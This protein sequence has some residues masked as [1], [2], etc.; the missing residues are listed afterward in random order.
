MDHAVVAVDLETTGFDPEVDRIIEIGAVRLEPTADGGLEAGERFATFVDPGRPLP[1]AIGR[2]TGI[3]DAHLAGAPQPSE[4]VSAFAA[5]AKDAWLAGHNVAFDVAFLERQGLAPGA[6]CLDTVELAS[7]LYP[8]APSYALQSLAAD[9][10]IDAGSA[11][12]ALDDALTCGALLGVLL[13][14]ARGLDPLILEEATA[15]A[16]FLG[17]ASA[18][19]FASALRTAVRGSWEA[20]SPLAAGLSANGTAAP[21][22]ALVSPERPGAP[23][24]DVPAA[25]APDGALASAFPGYEPRAEQVELA[26]AVE[27]TMAQGGV[28]LAEAGTGIGKSIA[29]LVPAIARA[30]RRERVVV[31]T[32]TLPLQ[33]QLVLRDLPAL[34]DALGTSVAVA[35]QKGRSNYLCPRRWQMMRG[36]AATREEARLILKTLVWRTTTESGDRAELNL[37]GSE[38][39]L[40][41]R[42][43]A[44]DEGCDSRRCARTP[45]GCYLERARAAAGKAGIVVVNHALLLQ[46]ARGRAGLLPDAEHVVVDEAHRLEDVAADAFGLSL[47]QARL[48]RDIERVAHSPLVIDSLKDPDLAETAAHMRNECAGALERTAETFGTLGDL[49]PRAGMEDRLRVTAGLRASD[50]L[51]L[52]VELAAERLGDSL[53]EVIAAGERL[54]ARAA[55]EDRAADLVSGAA[56]LSRA[57]SGLARAV[58]QPRP[59]DIVWLALGHA[60]VALR[61]APSHV[62]AALRRGLVEPHRSIVFTSATLAVARSLAF[63]LERF[64]IADVA[65]TLRV[66]SPFDY[67]RQAALVVPTDISYPHEESF[68]AEVASIVEETGRALQGRTMV[69]FTAHSAMRDVAAR[70]SGL[71]E[72]GIAVLT[73]GVDGSRRSLLRRF[74]S[75]RA[76]LLGTQSFWEGVDLPGDVL[77]CVVIAKLPFAVPDDPLVEGRAERYEDPFREFHLPQAVLRLRQGFGRLIR[78]RSDRGAVVLLDRRVL[79]REY[80]PAFLLSLPPARLQ[81]VESGAVAGALASWCAQPDDGPR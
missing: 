29:Y 59:G 43:C 53:A 45:G 65:A 35:V 66:G 78:T 77:R 7:I 67:A 15:H 81:R 54:A 38:G 42:I 18:A 46:N 26:L 55:D 31:S 33:D 58:H 16:A 60:G 61:V 48:R 44:D 57:K 28:L 20:A 14:R 9:T 74:A 1:P 12:R 34:Q 69:L 80:G 73:Q 79:T 39:T 22:S 13:D 23:P 56:E 24:P 2:L 76:V 37:F 5:F 51:W 6:V 49:V 52:P 40:W 64:G 17:P 32:H 41:S 19:F 47:D 11:H 36:S 27:S 3:A 50:E 8:G 30:A 71:E 21:G 68:A 63:T 72:A 10:A 4:A 62:G 75:G 25:F 70:L